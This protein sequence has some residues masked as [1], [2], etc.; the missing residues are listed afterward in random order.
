MQPLF[1]EGKIHFRDGAEFLNELE[2]ELLKFDPQLKSQK[3]DL[4]D[5]LANVF[6]MQT[7]RTIKTKNQY[8]TNNNNAYKINMRSYDRNWNRFFRRSLIRGW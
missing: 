2:T 4:I 3:D 1:K 7:G 5:A 6:Q 8:F